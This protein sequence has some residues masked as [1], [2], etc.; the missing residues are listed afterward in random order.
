MLKL[1]WF[2]I[3]FLYTTTALAGH[4]PSEV[5]PCYASDVS[6]SVDYKNGYFDGMSHSGALIVLYNKGSQACSVPARP[7][8]G[9]EDAKHIALPASRQLPTRQPGT[10]LS[11]IMIQKNTSITSQIRW[12]SSE[13]FDNSKCISPAFITLSVGNELLRSRFKG[14]L[15]GPA[16]KNPTYTLTLFKHGS[17]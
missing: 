10:A 17:I 13:V 11:S 5:A 9:F 15:C 14:N 7:I 2:S 1:N 4:A 16:D 6:F 12:V 8:V 3:I